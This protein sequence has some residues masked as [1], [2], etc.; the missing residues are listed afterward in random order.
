[1][2]RVFRIAQR[3]FAA[4]FNSPVAYVVL[5]VFLA[6]CGVLFF[7]FGPLFIR[8]DASLRSFFGLMPVVF[9]FLA[10]AVTMRLVAEE[11]K[12][13]TIEGLLTLPVREWEVV[14]GKFLGAL[15]MVLVGLAFTLPYPLSLAALTAPQVSLDWGPVIGGYVGSILLAASFIA[16][17]LWASALGKDQIVGFIVGLAVCFALWIPD[18]VSIFFPETLGA[19]LQFLSA[20][21]HFQNIA[22]GVID[23]RDVL[24]Y[25]TV[26]ATGLIGTTRL[27]ENVR[28]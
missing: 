7:F 15:G 10:P 20:N 1:M 12:R 22:R 26:T 28:K 23:S 24:Y 3:E 18:Q 13:G 2:N 14:A 17:G 21:F 25:V 9:M 4:F 27:L 19:A 6:L 11:R 8:N 5:G 16:V